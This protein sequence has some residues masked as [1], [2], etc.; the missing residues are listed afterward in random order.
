ML[1]A[2]LTRYAGKAGSSFCGR[3]NAHIWL[4]ML[5]K[6][7]WRMCCGAGACAAALAHVLKNKTDAAYFRGHLF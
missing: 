2:D 3:A 6:R 5:S 1:P 7:R 4:G